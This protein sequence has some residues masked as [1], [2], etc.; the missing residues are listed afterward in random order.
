MPD[1][2]TGRTR[3]ISAFRRLVIDLMHFSQRVPTA[4]V[5]R[6]LPLGPLVAARDAAADPVTWSA[7][8][9]KAYA[10]VAARNPPLRTAYLTHPWPRFYEYATSVATVNVDREL[11]DERVVVY[12]H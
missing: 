12:A 8:F 11:G 9:V 10:R 1:P 7:I 4:A 6:P 5:E 2:I 3:R